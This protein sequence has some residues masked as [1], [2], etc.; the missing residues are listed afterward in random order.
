[1]E[2]SDA[3]ALED[4]KAATAPAEPEEH[5]PFRQHKQDVSCA[6]SESPRQSRA[7]PASGLRGRATV[8]WRH[9]QRA[10][11]R[12]QRAARRIMFEAANLATLGHLA[13]DMQRQVLRLTHT[14]RLLCIH[15]WRMRSGLF[16]WVPARLALQ[17]STRRNLH[18]IHPFRL[19]FKFW[20][21]IQPAPA[22]L[23]LTVFAIF[24]HRG[25]E[26]R[27]TLFHHAL[28]PMI[29]PRPG[30]YG[31]CGGEAAIS[32][33]VTGWPDYIYIYT[34]IYTYIHICT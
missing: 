14:S 21:K 11:R 26:T 25:L 28:T 4:K 7:R 3:S 32:I 34:Y 23:H 30:R 18:Q 15:N 1:M 33:V 6:N 17:G 16:C 24:A 8:W 31:G 20:F 19:F 9:V 22:S 10:A 29:Q 5:P 13:R 2:S 12:V 27:W